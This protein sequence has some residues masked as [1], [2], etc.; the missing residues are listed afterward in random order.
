MRMLQ[1]FVCAVAVCA[2]GCG[3]EGGSG[4]TGRTDVAGIGTTP[5]VALEADAIIVTHACA[6]GGGQSL[7][8]LALVDK[9]GY[10]GRVKAGQ[11]VSGMGGFSFVLAIT[12]AS[13]GAPGIP[14]GSYPIPSYRYAIADYPHLGPNDTVYAG[15]AVLRLDSACSLAA[16]QEPVSGQV[17]ILSSSTSGISGT[18][19]GTAPDGTHVTG[20]FSAVACDVGT[21]DL[22]TTFTLPDITT[23][24]P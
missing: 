8:R 2:S 1:G 13:G 23:C 14:V 19:D 3:G 12:T 11:T 18:V 20:S 22:C 24:L 5:F 16:D 9:A 7:L 4:Y 15:A 10:C 21:G 6:G 17:T